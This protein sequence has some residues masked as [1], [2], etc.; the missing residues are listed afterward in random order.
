MSETITISVERFILMAKMCERMSILT[1]YIE[2]RNG[3]YIDDD[4]VCR[5]VTGEPNHK[6]KEF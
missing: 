2:S 4:F 3:Q 5:I 1:E 6:E